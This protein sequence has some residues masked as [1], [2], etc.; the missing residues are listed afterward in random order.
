[1][2]PE[3]PHAESR[4]AAAEPTASIPPNLNSSR[5]LSFLLVRPS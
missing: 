2:L 1:V 4:G 3:P 5:R